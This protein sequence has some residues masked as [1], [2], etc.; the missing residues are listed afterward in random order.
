MA[1]LVNINKQVVILVLG[2][3]IVF[4]GGVWLGAALNAEYGQS[5]TVGS[6]GVGGIP[7]AQQP[8]T[9]KVKSPNN[10][11]FTLVTPN[12]DWKVT[13]DQSTQFLSGSSIGPSIGANQLKK[14]DIKKDDSVTVLGVP[15]KKD[16]TLTA[17]TVT[18]QTPPSSSSSPSASATPIPALAPPPPA[19]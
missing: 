5:N 11:G 14:S 16:K 9:G 15:G 2:A 17:R 4:G 19:R 1:F 3:V 8:L 6:T 12:G 18:K 7:I 13:Y 10:N